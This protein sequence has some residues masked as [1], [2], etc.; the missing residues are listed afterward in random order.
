MLPAVLL[1]GR[2][3]LELARSMGVVFFGGLV[4]TLL[5]YLFVAPALYLVTVPSDNF[6]TELRLDVE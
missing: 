3:G 2:A 6:G 4:T 1:G 5:V